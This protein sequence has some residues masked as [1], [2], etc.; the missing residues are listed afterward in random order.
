M[1]SIIKIALVLKLKFLLIILSLGSSYLVEH[2]IQK[3]RDAV[4]NIEIIQPVS[5]LKG[6]GDI[7]GIWGKVTEVLRR[8]R[9]R[10]ALARIPTHEG[11]SNPSS[12]AKR[13]NPG[14]LKFEA[15]ES[16]TGGGNSDGPMLKTEGV[17][18]SFGG[19]RALQDVT[20]EVPRGKILGIIGPNGAGKTTLFNVMNG[21]LRPEQGRIFFKGEDVTHLKP[22]GL[23][24]RGVGR[25]FQIPQIFNKMTVLENV[26]VGAFAKEGHAARAQ[27]IAEEIIQKMELSH[28]AEDQA[29]GLTILETKMLEFSRALATQPELILVDEPMAGLNPEEAHHIGE[30]IKGVAASGTTVIVI[31]H[32]VQSLVKIADRMVGLDDG[33]KVAEGLPEEVTSDPHMIEAYLGEKWRKRYAKG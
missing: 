13:G 32:V 26:L 2:S 15:S 1:N 25:T 19:V 20:I 23:C 27:V 29:V 4:P 28:R 14:S 5:N 6:T 18:K 21:Y 16:G 9:Q 10:L 7:E 24:Q 31:E 22:H 12:A 8:R 11:R 33:R 30:I 17:S 3:K